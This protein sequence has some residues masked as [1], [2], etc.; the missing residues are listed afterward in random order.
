MVQ[1]LRPHHQIADL[2]GALDQLVD[3][4]LRRRAGRARPGSTGSS[5]GRQASGPA[6]R[7][8]L[9]GPYTSQWPP[10]KSGSKNG[11]PWM[12]S[13]WVWPRRIDPVTGSPPGRV[14]STS[15]R[16]RTRAPV[17]QSNTTSVPRPERSSTHDVLPPYRT[18][19]GPGV[20]M[21]PRVPQY[22]MRMSAGCPMPAGDFARF[23]L[24]HYRD[25]SSGYCAAI[26]SARRAR[27][28]RETSSTSTSS[29]SAA[30]A[31]SVARATSP[32]ESLSPGIPAVR[33]VSTKPQWTPMTWMARGASSS[34]RLLVSD[35]AAAFDAQ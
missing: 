30:M 14:C 16:P 26:G 12:W 5:S 6:T 24:R 3:T 29:W 33:S 25:M 9:C 20:A 18:V 11:R 23:G 7:R 19:D 2:E 34:R 15:A 28:S 1:V 10:P 8:G 22:R 13:Q 27:T 4:R 21:E 31:A 32:G 35:H 17:P